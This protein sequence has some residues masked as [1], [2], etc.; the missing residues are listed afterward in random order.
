MNDAEVI[1]KYAALVNYIAQSRTRQQ[2]DAEDVFQDVFLKYVDKQ[3]E[4]RSEEHAK[5]WF[6][7]VTI[8]TAASMYRRHAFAKREDFE[9]ETVER[10]QMKDNP[11]QDKDLNECEEFYDEEENKI[12]MAHK[13]NAKIIKG[14]NP[15][16]YDLQAEAENNKVILEEFNS[17][18]ESK[19]SKD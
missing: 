16:Y 9:E 19:K 11:G 14:Y 2:S 18:I 4:F 8:N 6:I 7:R 5:A 17:Y 1:K 3:P 15:K 12:F 10:R 13:L